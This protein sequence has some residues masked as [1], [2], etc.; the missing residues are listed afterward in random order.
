MAE[1]SSAMD[2]PKDEYEERWQRVYAE[3]E[4]RGYRTL[5]VWQRSGGGYDRAGNVWWLAGYASQASGQDR[6]RL[7]LTRAGS[8]HAAL[9]FHDRQEPELHVVEPIELIDTRRVAVERILSSEHLYFSVATRLREQSID[10]VAYVGDDMLPASDYRMLMAATPG[11]V[12]APEDDLLNLPTLVKSPREL[13]V[14]RTAGDVSSRALTRLMEGLIAGAPEADAAAAAASI[15]IASGG[16]FQ[17]VCA[18]HGSDSELI[19]WSDALYGYTTD[20][21]QPGEM[22]RGWVYGPITKGYW[23]DPGRSAVCGNRPTPD[24][25]EAIETCIDLIDVIIGA[26]KLGSTP[27]Q[28]TLEI[29]AAA[30]QIG[31]FTDSALFFETYGH[32]LGTF[33]AHPS[34]LPGITAGVRVPTQL[35]DEPFRSGQVMTAEAFLRRPGV[36][37]AT[38]EDVFILTDDGPEMLTTTPRVFW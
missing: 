35:V 28:A 5:V 14:F 36:G 1:T 29:E 30:R 3:M 10:R 26:V 2:F 25:R 8:A 38:F 27:R 33:F 34:L 13:E 22:V 16:G 18:H 21:P 4:R 12:W 37:N 9:V 31:Y 32:G 7:R 17:R 15:I 6:F 23:V 11:V 20:A 24:Q 19:T